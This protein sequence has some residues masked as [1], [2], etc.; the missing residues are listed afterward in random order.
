M[1]MP[2][3]PAP[4]EKRE[5]FADWTARCADLPRDLIEAA[6]QD[7]S[8]YEVEFRRRV[9]DH[10]QYITTLRELE[11]FTR[12]RWPVW[13][14]WKAQSEHDTGIVSKVRSGRDLCQFLWAQ[15]LDHLEREAR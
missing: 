13:F 12:E 10:G 1:N 14:K 15:W 4:P 7:R 3:E 6:D 9:R 8:P 2:P 5:T 11:R